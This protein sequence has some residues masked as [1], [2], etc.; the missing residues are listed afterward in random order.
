ML[1]HTSSIKNDQELSWRIAILHKSISIGV[2]KELHSI[3]KVNYVLWSLKIVLWRF[4]EVRNNVMVLPVAFSLRSVYTMV[5]SHIPCLVFINTV[6]FFNNTFMNLYRL[7]DDVCAYHTLLIPLLMMTY[8]VG[9]L[10]WR[11]YVFSYH[12]WILSKTTF[13][14]RWDRSFLFCTWALPACLI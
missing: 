11:Y 2:S 1:E 3:T 4:T 5:I 7:R 12:L 6:R 13:L 9:V 14:V 10:I 8:T